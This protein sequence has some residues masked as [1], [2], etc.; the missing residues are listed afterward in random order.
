MPAWDR[1]FA[2]ALVIAVSCAAVGAEILRRRRQRRFGDPHLFGATEGWGVIAASGMLF[3]ASVGTLSGI[4]VRRGNGTQSRPPVSELA[5][6]IDGG[7]IDPVA[8]ERG[9]VADALRAVAPQ[10]P[11][12]RIGVF[13]LAPLL[14]EIAPWTFDLEGALILV[15]RVAREASPS[16]SSLPEQA[17]TLLGSVGAA[18]PGRRVVIVTR[19]PASDIEKLF[20]REGGPPTL[21][22]SLN[23]VGRAQFGARPT[24]GAW[25]WASEPRTP[26]SMLRR[27][28]TPGAGLRAALGL[29]QVLAGLALLLLT[30]ERLLDWRRDRR[31]GLPL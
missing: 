22:V 24:A 27:R 4:L 14:E 15:D 6:V 31:E 29:V 23:D 28:G 26:A 20:A 8:A 19:L 25:V 21:A 18:S 30:A 3:V 13:R 12:S 16:L 2:T 1:I 11:N 9:T 7:V 17:G 10:F 5:I